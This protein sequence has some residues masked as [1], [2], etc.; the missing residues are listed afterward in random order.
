MAGAEDPGSRRDPL[1]LAVLEACGISAG[2]ARAAEIE[3]SFSPAVELDKG[4]LSAG[5]LV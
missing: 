1:V 3:K 5:T 2:D 4:L